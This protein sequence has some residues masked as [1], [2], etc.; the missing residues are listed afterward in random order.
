MNTT[1]SGMSFAQPL[2]ETDPHLAIP[3]LVIVGVATSGGVI[4]NSMLI[5]MFLNDKRKHNKLG[6]EFLMNMA[7]A[8]LMVVSIINPLCIIGKCFINIDLNIRFGYSALNILR[9]ITNH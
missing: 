2:L 7:V 9:T 5:Y 3:Y 6:T 1:V 4:G 8:D